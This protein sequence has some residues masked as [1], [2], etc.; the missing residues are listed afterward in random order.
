MAFEEFQKNGYEY[1]ITTGLK[2]SSDYYELSVNGYLIFHPKIKKSSSIEV[3]Q[4]IIEVY[5]YGS[6]NG[7]YSAHFNLFVNHS[8]IA[9]FLADKHKRRYSATWKGSLSEID[10]IMVQ[11]TNDK[12]DEYGDINLFIKE[13]LIDHNIIIPYLNNSEFYNSNLDGNSR[14]VNNFNSV[15]ELARNWLLSKGIDSSSIIAVPGERVIINRTLTSALAFRAWLRTTNIDIKGINIISLGTHARRTWMT[16]NKILDEKYDI[17]IIS[18]P[19]PIYRHSRE[20]KV[21]KT[22]RETLGI[23]YYWFI[24]IPY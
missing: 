4:H 23:I 8:L 13:V 7:E 19:E 21:F 2:S 12:V 6:L 22:I 11:F 14:I 9:D 16:F 5:A 24:L 20:R 3:S 17:G 18:I 1:I 15:A 10:S